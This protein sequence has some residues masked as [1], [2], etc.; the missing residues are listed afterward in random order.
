M[1]KEKGSSEIFDVKMEN[2]HSK[3]W[4]ESFF[5]PP[6][7]A[8]SFRSC[9]Y[10]WTGKSLDDGG[11]I[12]ETQ[13]KGTTSRRVESLDILDLLGGRSPKE[14]DSHFQIQIHLLLTIVQ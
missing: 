6:N 2:S 1:T 5:S 3:I 7:S 10:V 4:P 11:R 9:V 8:P 13:G 14:E 12:L